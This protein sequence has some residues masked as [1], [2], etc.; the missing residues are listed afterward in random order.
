MTGFNAYC[1]CDPP[2]SAWP[3]LF[4]SSERKYFDAYAR[5]VNAYIESH[6]DHL[7]AE[8]RLLAYS[9]RPWRIADS[10]VIGLSMVQ[11]L[12]EH[13]TEK[14]GREKLSGKLS[15]ELLKDL[16]PTGSWRD[17]PPTASGT[18]PDPTAARYS[19]HAVG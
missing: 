11:T 7:P 4:Q 15:P 1:R 10:V 3:P 2:P 17:H 13:F 5:G 12:D 8:F 9:P 14:L 16:Y 19:G 18:R 6:R